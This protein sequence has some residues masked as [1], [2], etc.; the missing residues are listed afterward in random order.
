MEQLLD[1]IS[2]QVKKRRLSG[3]VNMDSPRG[4][5]NLVVFYDVISG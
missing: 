1:V 2:K 5:T 4:I 3:V